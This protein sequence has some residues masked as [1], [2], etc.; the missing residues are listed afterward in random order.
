MIG[1]DGRL[2]VTRLEMDHIHDRPRKVVVD[3]VGLFGERAELAE[4]LARKPGRRKLE[5]QPGFA[6]HV[7]VQ[8]FC[9]FVRSTA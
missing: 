3:Q 8:A 2:A 4:D 5:I 1:D 7:A 9:V 6:G